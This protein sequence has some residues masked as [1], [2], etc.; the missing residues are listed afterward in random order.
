MRN[1]TD[2]CPQNV[3][4]CYWSLDM[5]PAWTNDLRMVGASTLLPLQGEKP[6]SPFI[7]ERCPS[8]SAVGL[9]ARCYAW[10]IPDAPYRKLKSCSNS[11]S[12]WKG[13]LPTAQC[14]HP[15]RKNGDVQTAPQGQKRFCDIQPTPQKKVRNLSATHLCILLIIKVSCLTY[16]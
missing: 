9:S 13:I 7:L 5:H 15:G 8:L 6:T 11:P 16:S 2:W 4:F 3:L 12:P 14:K 10:I 1:W